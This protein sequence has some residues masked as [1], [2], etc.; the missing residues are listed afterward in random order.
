MRCD[1][2]R[3]L[4]NMNEQARDISPE[5]LS[6]HIQNCPNCRPGIAQLSNALLTEA[7]LTCE[8]CRLLFPVYYEATRPSY[9]LEEM[10][11]VE[12]LEMVLHLRACS[13]CREEYRVFTLLSEME[14]RDEIIDF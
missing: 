13:A 10:S 5:T 3:H 7:L 8:Q 9:P 14:E 4:L 1:E 2:L 12:L 11:D 6:T